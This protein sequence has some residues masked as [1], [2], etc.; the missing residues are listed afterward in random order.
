MFFTHYPDY[1]SQAN[2][3]NRSIYLLSWFEG[4]IVR[5]WADAILMSIGSPQQSPMLTNFELLTRTATITWGPINQEHE[6]RQKLREL[7][8]E[9]TISEY[10]A[11]FLRW[12]AL[13]GFNREAL[14]DFFYRGLKESIK[15]MMINIRRPTTLEGMLTAALDYESRI[16]ERVQERRINEQ[17]RPGSDRKGDQKIKATRL[18]PEERT[19][20]MKEGRCFIC[21]ETG[22]MARTCPKRTRIKAAKTDEK[23]EETEET[24]IEEVKEDF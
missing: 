4:D 24:K 3:I 12:S 15:N 10:H 9:K 23:K 16:M 11:N 1:F 8:Q 6:A 21:N 13:S 5:P 20:R 14:V 22:H 19:K 18:S 2:L 17:Y 7:R